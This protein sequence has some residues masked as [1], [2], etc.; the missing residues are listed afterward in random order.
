MEPRWVYK[1]TCRRF[2]WWSQTFTR[3]PAYDTHSFLQSKNLLL[4]YIYAV[5]NIVLFEW[6]DELAVPFFW[7]YSWHSPLAEW[8]ISRNQWLW[9]NPLVGI[10][11]IQENSYK[12]SENIETVTKN[13]R[14]MSGTRSQIKFSF[15]YW[16][17][18]HLEVRDNFHPPQVWESL[19]PP[20]QSICKNLVS[21]YSYKTRGASSFAGSNR[22]QTSVVKRT[23]SICSVLHMPT[24]PMFQYSF[25]FSLFPPFS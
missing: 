13:L 4:V 6:A 19:L 3:V 22:F 9:K 16:Q 7:S 15:E 25:A 18:Q 21:G 12:K 2:L 10:S 14:T 20:A 11:G 17:M 5:F 8:S 1:N 23:M 24:N